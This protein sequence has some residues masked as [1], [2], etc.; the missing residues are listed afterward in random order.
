MAKITD[1][2]G[3]QFKILNRSKGPAVWATRVQADRALYRKFMRE[4]VE[5]QDGLD[6]RQENV[7]EILVQKGHVTG[8]KTTAAVYRAKILIIATGTFLKGLV[9][10]GQESCPSGRAGEP[11][12]INLSKSLGNLGLKIGRLKTGTPPRIVKNTKFRV[13]TCLLLQ[14]LYSL[15]KSRIRSYRALSHIQTKARIRQLLIILN[16][17]R[18]TVGK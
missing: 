14:C 12:S 3:I 5:A 11:P 9:H 7:E 17:P 16:I 10:I 2:A 4:A 15:K 13:V 18:F 6:I 1:K 8:I